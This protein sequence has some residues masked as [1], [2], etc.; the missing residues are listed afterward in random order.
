MT[1]KDILVVAPPRLSTIETNLPFQAGALIVRKRANKRKEATPQPPGEI[2][3]MMLALKRIQTMISLSGE[4]MTVEQLRLTVQQAVAF[5]E[6][7][8]LPF[9]TRVHELQG[10]YQAVMDSL[11]ER[12]SIVPEVQETLRA[13][14]ARN[15][16]REFSQQ[17]QEHSK[18]N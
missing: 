16:L 14:L 18:G 10:A 15:R 5:H 17:Q 6:D 1:P 13:V 2:E 3:V 8:L 12:A 4:Q 11:V 9:L 7:Q